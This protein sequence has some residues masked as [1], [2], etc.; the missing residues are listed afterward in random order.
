MELIRHRHCI[1]INKHALQLQLQ[2]CCNPDPQQAEV[3]TTPSVGGLHAVWSLKIS[4]GSLATRSADTTNRFYPSVHT[5][6]GPEADKMTKPSLTFK[7]Q[8]ILQDGFYQE[9]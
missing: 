6:L 8:Y 5:S 9:I 4:L 3:V 2:P 1:Q 7:Q